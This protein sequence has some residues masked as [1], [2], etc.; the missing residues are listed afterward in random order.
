[1]ANLKEISD[2]F[3]KHLEEER[4]ALDEYTYDDL[5]KGIGLD[6]P[7]KNLDL[8]ISNIKQQFQ[9]IENKYVLGF[10]ELYHSESL[11]KDEIN[12]IFQTIQKENNQNKEFLSYY[13]DMLSEIINELQSNI[14][15]APK[16]QKHIQGK[17]DKTLPEKER[18]IEYAKKLYEE[19]PTLTKDEILEKIKKNLVITKTDEHIKRHWLK[20]LKPKK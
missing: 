12:S 19:E 10:S 7:E 5:K 9:S 18:A 16:F 20:G 11:S 6:L 3:I 14:R 4:I 13:L 8:L 15:V 17:T 2:E 1:M